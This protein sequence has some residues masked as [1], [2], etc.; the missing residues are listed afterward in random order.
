MIDRTPLLQNHSLANAALWPATVAGTIWPA[1][2]LLAV[3]S[4]V[5]AL[6]L[7]PLRPMLVLSVL[8]SLTIFYHS[9]MGFANERYMVVIE[10]LVY[11]LATLVPCGLLCLKLKRIHP[12]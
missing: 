2:I 4:F 10:P 3:F 8:V 7:R 5:V 11:V 6:V 9:L 1:A 12:C